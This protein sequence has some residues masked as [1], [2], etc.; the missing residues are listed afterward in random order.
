[1]L[2]RATA[3]PTAAVPRWTWVLGLDSNKA[4]EQVN[5]QDEQQPGSRKVGREH[6]TPHGLKQQR[7]LLWSLILH[8]L[9]LFSAGI[10]PRAQ[11]IAPNPPL[12]ITLHPPAEPASPNP[13]A[14][15][16]H[17]S[18]APR[19]SAPPARPGSG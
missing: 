17:V 9:N 2:M 7:Q 6:L 12:S 14:L 13:P 16:Y 8:V 4:A 5:K 3:A 10:S 11:T 15:Y 19:P 1:M 18:P